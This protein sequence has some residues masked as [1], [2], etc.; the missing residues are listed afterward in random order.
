MRVVKSS[1]NRSSTWLKNI[2]DSV[3]TTS[4]KYLRSSGYNTRSI[5]DYF[6]VEVSPADP[7]FIHVEITS[8]LNNEDLYDLC[9]ILDKMVQ[10]RF[11]K[12]AYFEPRG[13]GIADSYITPNNPTS[14]DSL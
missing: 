4:S 7:G 11:D 6:E 8:D 9:V 14:G 13:A 12:Y 1:S 3:L 2:H 10:E 5:K